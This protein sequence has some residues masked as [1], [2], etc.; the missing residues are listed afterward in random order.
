[1]NKKFFKFIISFILI[2]AIFCCTL[3]VSAF[4]ISGFELNAR[5]AILISLDTDEVLYSKNADQKMYPASITKLLVAA[6]VLDKTQNLDNEVITYTNDANNA[7]L[8]TGASV[9]GLK[10]GEE[11]TARQALYCLLISSGG[12]VAYAIAEHYGGSTES[13]MAMMNAKAQ[14]IGMTSSNFGNPVG[15]HDDYT[16]TTPKDVSLLAKYVLKY[17]II[18]EIT[19]LARYQLPATNMSGVRYLSTTNFLID[20]ATNYFYKYAKGLKTGFTDEAGRCVVSTASLDGYSYLCIVM[21]CTTKGG[22]RN[23]FVD[24]RNLYR[25]AFNNF[26]YKSVLDITKPVAEI[27]V[28]LSLNTDYIPLFPEKSVTS[29]L[30]IKADESTITIDTTLVSERV[31]AP[32]A[33]GTVLGTADILYAGE[34][35]GTVNLISREDVKPNLFLQIGAVVKGIVSSTAFKILLVILGVGVLVFIGIC[36]RLNTSNKKRR[37][38]K[39]IPYDKDKKR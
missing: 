35:I 9:I 13:F 39:Y 31:K 3:S 33:A 34:V 24:S 11:L 27:P 16:Y 30:P 17:D 22:V 10:I 29:I 6:I 38:V 26:E 5:G 25:W 32:V 21:G 37:K 20:P 36:I 1:M 12:D 7:I 28:D 23:E 8:G 19:S 15:L 18:L 2:F 4:Q 14:E